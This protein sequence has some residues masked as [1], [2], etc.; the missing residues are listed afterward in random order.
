MIIAAGNDSLFVKL[1]TALDRPDLAENPLF[2]TNDLRNRHGDA[3]KCEIEGVLRRHTREHWIA[4]LEKAGIP[5]GPINNVAEALKHPQVE[6]R[7]MLVDAHDATAGTVRI[8]GNPL[9]FSAFPD[10]K[11]RPGAPDL[12]GDRAKI[13]KELGLSD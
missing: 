7:N 11:T 13:L 3:L 4:V 1:C 10:P 12:D 2:K 6:A 5:C 9:K 8:A